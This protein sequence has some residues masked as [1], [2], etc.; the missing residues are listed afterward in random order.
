MEL[1]EINAVGWKADEKTILGWTETEGYPA[2]M[3]I[4]DGQ[5]TGVSEN[6]HT[7]YD[8]ESLAKFAFSIFWRA[9]KFAQ[10]NQ[11]PILLDF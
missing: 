1:N 11:V 6:E 3:D 4:R 5:L 7:C 10:E 9:V 2:D 8:T